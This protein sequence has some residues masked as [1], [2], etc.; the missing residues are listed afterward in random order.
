ME[1][2][3]FISHTMEDGGGGGGGWGH[4]PDIFFQTANV[5]DMKLDN[6]NVHH[7]EMFWACLKTMRCHYFLLMLSHDKCLG[8]L[9]KYGIP[10]RTLLFLNGNRF[11]SSILCLWNWRLFWKTLCLSLVILNWYLHGFISTGTIVP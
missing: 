7:E 1:I 2:F 11:L 4:I 6:H 8:C 3:S 5:I 10:F 9:T